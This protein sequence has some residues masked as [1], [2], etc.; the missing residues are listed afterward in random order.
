MLI[1]HVFEDAAVKRNVEGSRGFLLTNKSGGFAF[2]GTGQ[3]T[4]RFQG[5]HFARDFS[6]FKAIDSIRLLAS[7]PDTLENNFFSIDRVSG[8]AR[9][10]FFTNHTDTLLY[11]V[12][13]FN[14]F[15]EL[16]LDCRKMHDYHDQGRIYDIYSQGDAIIVEYT[17][18]KDSSLTEASYR[19]FVAIRGVGE[20]EKT[21][22]WERTHYESDEKR[23][24]PPFDMYVYRALK[25][26]I[27]GSRKLVFSYSDDKDE[28]IRNAGHSWENFEF[29]K[30][31]KENYV[32]TKLSGKLEGADL[33]IQLACKASINSIESFVITTTNG[34]TGMIA[35]YPWFA[36]F[37][38]R[39]EAMSLSSLI[40][41]ERYS[42]A[43]DILFRN[44][45]NI[46]D[47]GRMPNRR[48]DSMLGSADGVG[49]VWKRT[50]DL[51]LGLAKKGRLNE[52][53]SH[54][55]LVFMREQLKKSIARLLNLHT[56]EGL[57]ANS[58]L[59]TWMDTGYKEDL[60]E[61][62]RIEIQALRLCMYR[63]MAKLCILTDN[64]LGAKR[65]SELE[66][67]TVR[68]VRHEFY[69][70]PM[71]LDG[72][73]DET[74]RPN[75]FI[76]CY[77]YPWLLQKSEW[78]VC[79]D[80]ALESLWLDWGGLATIDRGHKYFSDKYTGEDNRS[81]HRGDSWYFLNNLAAICMHDIDSK[82]YG[83]HIKK[84]IS[85]ST[86][87]ILYGGIIG[88]HSELSSAGQQTS[89]AS[90][91]QAWS[92]AFYIELVGRVYGSWSS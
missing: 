89:E 25:L 13:G 12:G 76:A 48:P 29:I 52:F 84:I 68:R 63:L 7:E 14:G 45:G 57:S 44:I 83:D 80:S 85:A 30:K 36:Q 27:D 61:G 42:E 33:G 69:K 11:E 64:E 73:G 71:L 77:V 9:E 74:V 34:E 2:L 31:S 81:Y 41:E 62:F 21:G 66:E 65:Y 35:G 79:F 4:S 23:G 49:W 87:D 72:M 24:S 15:A 43:K 18:Y 54:D 67:V 92:S 19:I 60:R 47:D 82:A 8:K 17:K 58:A 53:I 90:L 28:A 50:M 70:K 91:A 78:K 38:T 55:E 40:S 88:F 32:K 56:K 22:I 46:L 51:L 39:D 10:T 1:S 59:E 16:V 37:W 20:Y 75:I 5:V 26:K 86:D 3:N 6:Y